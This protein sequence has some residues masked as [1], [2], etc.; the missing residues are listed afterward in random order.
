MS[1]F[2]QILASIFH[3]V[4]SA[5]PETEK[6]FATGFVP[7]GMERP[8]IR[9][10]DVEAVLEDRASHFGEKVDWRNSIADLMKLLELDSSLHARQEL[11]KELEYSG[12][13]NDSAKMNEWLHKQVMKKLA[14]SGGEVP[15]DLVH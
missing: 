11:A 8:V 5:P 7:A 2:G 14:A 6:P 13:L 15:A 10:V 4:P 1:I 9:K 12:D 3:G